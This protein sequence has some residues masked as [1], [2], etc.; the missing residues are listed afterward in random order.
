MLVCCRDVRSCVT[1]A[2]AVP[3]RGGARAGQ[4]RIGSARAHELAA[5]SW[6]VKRSSESEPDHSRPLGEQWRTPTRGVGGYRR[7]RHGMAHDVNWD[8][9]TPLMAL[10]V[11]MALSVPRCHRERET[12]ARGASFLV[13]EGVMCRSIATRQRRH[14]VRSCRAG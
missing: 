14:S 10:V 11:A 7:G 6:A 12:Q 1:N 13:N 4:G 8:H 5:A 9:F 3:M 2:A